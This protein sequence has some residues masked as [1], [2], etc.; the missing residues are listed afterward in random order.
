MSYTI[1]TT[2]S[3][4]IKTY[5]SRDADVTLLLFTEQFGL[6]HAVAKS[7]R[8]VKSKLRYS[9]QSL[10]FSSISLVKG[11]EV[12]RVTSAKKHISLYDKRL[13]I[14]YRGMFARILLFVE[15]F[16]PRETSESAIFQNIKIL[17]GLIF[18]RE[19]EKNVVT[20]EEIE[21]YELIFNLKTLYELGYVI[22]DNEIEGLINSQFGIDI[23]NSLKDLALNKKV[24]QVID[25]G[26]IE[27]HL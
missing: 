23:V 5:P 17:S 26:I 1:F 25:K 4:I 16:C 10:S 19:A 7:A 8:Q 21:N 2:D 9:L 12:W 11:R 18:K 22:L 27:S 20:K 13:P 6:V 24:R 14:I 15:R 3:F